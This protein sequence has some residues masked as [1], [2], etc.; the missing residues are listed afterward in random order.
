MF[1]CSAFETSATVATLN[2]FLFPVL[3]FAVIFWF[4]C[5]IFLD[6]E[7]QS[8]LRVYQAPTVLDSHLMDERFALDGNSTDNDNTAQKAGDNLMLENLLAKMAATIDEHKTKK[9]ESFDVDTEHQNL[10]AL[11]TR[12]L[13][14]FCRNSKIKGYASAYNRSGLDGLVDFLLAQQIYA[15]QI[16]QQFKHVETLARGH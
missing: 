4:L 5:E 13:R 9:S 11:G 2:D 6:V 14:D 1:D 3:L 8:S 10:K 7:T 12:K 15:H 16:E